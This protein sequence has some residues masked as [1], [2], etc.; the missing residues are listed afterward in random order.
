MAV[1]ALEEDLPRVVVAGVVRRDQLTL[2][3]GAEVIHRDVLGLLR[4]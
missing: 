1:D 2:E 3:L 4:S